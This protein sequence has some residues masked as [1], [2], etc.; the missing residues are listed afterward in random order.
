MTTFL[1]ALLGLYFSWYILANV[2]C[3]KSWLQHHLNWKI[4]SRNIDNIYVSIT[5]ICYLFIGLS[6]YGSNNQHAILYFHTENTVILKKK[7]QLILATNMVA[8][9]FYINSFIA[10]VYMDYIVNVIC[11]IYQY[12]I[13]QQHDQDFRHLC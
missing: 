13:Q 10:D 9:L 1:L 6:I 5:C 12:F 7:H 2:L 8:S 3:Y 4:Q 11:Q